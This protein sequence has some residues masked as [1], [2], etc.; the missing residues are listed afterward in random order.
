MSRSGFSFVRLALAS[1]GSGFAV[2]VVSLPVIWA[3]SRVHPWLSLAVTVLAL[4]AMIA[5]IGF[6]ANRVVDKA[7][8]QLREA[9]RTRPNPGT[10]SDR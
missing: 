7:A 2:L 3:A 5:A 9:K 10:P 6:V 4:V 8:E 1:L